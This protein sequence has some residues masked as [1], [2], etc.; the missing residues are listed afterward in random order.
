MKQLKREIKMLITVKLLGWV[1]SIIPKE[2]AGFELINAIII[3]LE[4]DLIE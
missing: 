1:I 2:K 4:K 3:Y